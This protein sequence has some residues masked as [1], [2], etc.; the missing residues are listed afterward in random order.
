MHLAPAWFSATLLSLL[1]DSQQ[2]AGFGVL[3]VQH[4]S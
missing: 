1:L 4:W 2:P 3:P